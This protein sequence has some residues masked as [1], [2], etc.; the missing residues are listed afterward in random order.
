MRQAHSQAALPQ[1]A[2]FGRLGGIGRAS[3]IGLDNGALSRFTN[4][5]Q[6]AREHIGRDGGEAD[7][8]AF[9]TGR[10]LCLGDEIFGDFLYGLA[11]LLGGD[12]R[13]RS[14]DLGLGL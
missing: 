3:Q 14:D 12:V 4:F 6:P 9:I 11:G 13:L 7:L 10:Y 8:D 2:L 5:Q 1:G